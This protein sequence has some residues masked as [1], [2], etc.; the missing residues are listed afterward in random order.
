MASIRRIKRD[1]DFLAN[2]REFGIT[3]YP[4]MVN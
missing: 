4:Q 2:E 3:Y 1:I